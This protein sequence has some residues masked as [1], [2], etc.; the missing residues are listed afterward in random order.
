MRSALE[1]LARKRAQTLLEDHRRVRE[2]SRAGGSVKGVELAVSVPFGLLF[3]PLDGFGVQFNHSYT[4]SSVAIPLA[5]LNAI[6]AP[7]SINL[8]LPGLSRN[9]EPVTFS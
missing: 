6:D 5:G 9:S 8:P 1:E 7:G 2:A 3:K 4:D